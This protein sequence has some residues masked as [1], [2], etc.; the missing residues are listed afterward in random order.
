[1]AGYLFCISSWLLLRSFL[2]SQKIAD[3]IQD[4]V[5]KGSLTIIFFCVF[6]L[7]PAVFIKQK[8]TRL[9]NPIKSCSRGV[10]FIKQTQF[11]NDF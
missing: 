2:F 6:R 9:G 1:M 5:K 11:T 8:Y 3:I 7:N 4:V 10:T